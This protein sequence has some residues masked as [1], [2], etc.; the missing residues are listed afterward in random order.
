MEHWYGL[1]EALFD[2]RTVQDF[3]LDYNYND[4]QHR[5][6]QAGRLWKQAAP[7]G[8]PTGAGRRAGGSGTIPNPPTL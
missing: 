8:S 1:P 7:P 3:P 2:G 5:F 6:G 4:E